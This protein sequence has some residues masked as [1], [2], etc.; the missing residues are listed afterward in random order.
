[1][2]KTYSLRV[3]KQLA[4]LSL[5]ILFRSMPCIS[6]YRLWWGLAPLPV[7]NIALWLFSDTCRRH[8]VIVLSDEI[9]GRLTFNKP[10][11]SMAKV[12]L[13]STER[14]SSDELVPK[15]ADREQKMP[16]GCPAWSLLTSWTKKVMYH[17]GVHN[18]MLC[19]RTLPFQWWNQKIYCM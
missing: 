1:M 18:T 17:Y 7:L 5:K 10:H 16:L 9:Y 14:H 15:S 6:C 11:V 2:S 19:N 8:Q 3:G 13:C 12:S 4:A